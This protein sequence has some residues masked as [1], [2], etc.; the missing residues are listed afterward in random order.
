VLTRAV[1]GTSTMDLAALYSSKMLESYSREFA[2]LGCAQIYDAAHKYCI[3][4]DPAIVTRTPGRKLAAPV[5]PTVTDNDMLPCLQAMDAVP[6]GWALLIHNRS[7]TS[8]A[9][10]GD[11]YCT[12]AAAQNVAGLVIDGAVRDIEFFETLDL[13]VY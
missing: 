12:A 2:E 9:L 7:Q 10:A 4:M 1:K 3:A 8:E 6:P 13:P 5:F 11:I